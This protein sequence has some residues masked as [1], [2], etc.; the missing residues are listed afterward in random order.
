MKNLRLKYDELSP[1]AFGGLLACKQAIENSDLDISLLELISIRVSQI[2]GCAFCLSM[3]SKK[4]RKINEGDT[5]LDLLAGWK[6]SQQ[7]TDQEKAALGWAES[8]TNITADGGS[9][10]AFGKL[11][12]YFSEKQISDLTIAIANINAFNRIAIGMRQ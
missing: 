8:L 2:N 12:M 11:K 3:H 5:R 1:A 7:F 9:D 4:F 10:E 6:L